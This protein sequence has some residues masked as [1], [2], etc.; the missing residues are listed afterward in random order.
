MVELASASEPSSRPPHLTVVVDHRHLARSR[1][2]SLLDHPAVLLL[3][4]GARPSGAPAGLACST[5]RR[6]TQRPRQG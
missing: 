3:A 5:I 1:R 4:L 6:T 2:R